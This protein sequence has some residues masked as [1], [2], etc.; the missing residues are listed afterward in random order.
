MLKRFENEKF[1]EFK[2]YEKQL[3]KCALSVDDLKRFNTYFKITLVTERYEKLGRKNYP[4]NP[5]VRT[6]EEIDAWQLG[7]YASSIN[8]FGDRIEKGYTKGGYT[9]IKLTCHN[10]S[11]EIKVVRKFKYE[12]I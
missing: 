6:E 9:L 7:C 5:T 12:L 1:D 11:N 4:K 2:V 3:K 10:P 8:F